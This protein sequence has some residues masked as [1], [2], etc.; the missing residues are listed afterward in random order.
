MRRLI[1]WLPLP[2]IFLAYHLGGWAAKRIARPLADRLLLDWDLRLFGAIPGI[3]LQH[4]WPRP[5]L[6]GFELFYFSYYLFVP[7]APLVI[8]LRRGR[9]GLWRIWIAAG[10]TYLICDLLFPWFPSTPPRTLWPDF[11]PAG[12]AQ[13]MNRF[14]LD[15]FSIGANVFPS[16]HVAATLAMALC[17]WRYRSWWFLPWALG[18]AISTVSGG[19]HYGV[20]TAGGIAVGLLAEPTA[21]RIFLRMRGAQTQML[22][23]GGGSG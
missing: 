9:A 12:F 3:W 19:Y 13:V 22:P 18:I 14:V 20:D 1:D 11:A 17:H 23:S 4:H 8:F 7:L 5:V 15:R 21:S 6:D 16:S 10:L 2:A